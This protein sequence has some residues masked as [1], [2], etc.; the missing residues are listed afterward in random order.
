MK[1]PFCEG[2]D[3]YVVDTRTLKDALAI[4]RRRLCKNC[5][6]KFTT[7][8]RIEEPTI[9][10]IKSDGR[11]EPFDVNKIREGILKAI[12]KRPVSSEE[13]ER[14]VAEVQQEISKRF[15]LEVPSSLIG[16]IVLEK[17]FY[18]DPVAYVRFASVYYQY[19]S[20]DKFLKELRELKKRYLQKDKKKKGNKDATTK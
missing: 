19:D 13:V 20:I 12:E 16:K 15:V 17:L 9:N 11:R 10:V 6:K 5:Q 8:E 1:C 2:N 4:R 18:V 14:I 3:T 7:Y